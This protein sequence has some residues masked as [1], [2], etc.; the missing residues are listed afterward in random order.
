MEAITKLIQD[1]TGE[2]K[3]T[4]L[5]ML[6]IAF[7]FP[8]ATTTFLWLERDGKNATIYELQKEH[9]MLKE[10]ATRGI[11]LNTN[12]SRMQRR[13]HE[14]L[15]NSTYFQQRTCVNTASTEGERNKC[16]LRNKPLE[17]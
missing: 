2:W 11:A 6:F 17:E 14:L 9:I 16:L 13:N 12:I 7:T 5:T 1:I 4:M 3:R 8:F 10:I 15:S